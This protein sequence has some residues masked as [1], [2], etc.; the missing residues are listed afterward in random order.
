M[1]Q[2]EASP[3]DRR[4]FGTTENYFRWKR[5]CGVCDQSSLRINLGRGRSPS[6]CNHSLQTCPAIGVHLVPGRP[7]SKIVQNLNL[8]PPACAL[9]CAQD[10]SGPN[11][12]RHSTG[13]S[14][15]SRMN[16]VCTKIAAR[17]DPAS[18]RHLDRSQR[19]TKTHTAVETISDGQFAMPWHTSS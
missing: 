2:N 17:A 4:T 12:E 15:D 11:R 1:P 19:C 14:C 18:S 7:F 13:V 10:K 6:A 16:L 3:M 9:R 8:L 5:A